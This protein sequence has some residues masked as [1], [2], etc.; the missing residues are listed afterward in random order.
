MLMILF[1]SER[2]R[3]V[4]L[5]LIM[6]RNETSD[7]RSHVSVLVGLTLLLTCVA[8]AKPT[9]IIS[10]FMAANDAVSKDAEGKFTDWI[11]LHNYGAKA[12]DIGGLYLT[13]SKKDL[14]KF[15]LP[16]LN[17]PP[18]GY[19]L[20]WAKGED[21]EGQA[22]GNHT[23][24]RLQVKGDYLALVD[25]DG[26]S[27]IQDFGKKYPNQKTNVSF[28][29]TRDWFPGRLPI[30]Y[31]AFLLEPTPGAANSRALLG[32]VK[33]VS[34]NQ[35]RD[36]FEEPFDLKLKS[37]T[38]RAV[39][40][41]SID[42]SLPKEDS[43][44]VY[45]G[46]IRISKT[47]VLRTAAFKPG[48]L[49]SK[50]K[51]HSFIFAEDVGLQSSDGLP[52]EGFPYLWG[53][54][55][56][57]YGMDP[58]VINDPR[59]SDQFVNGLMSIPSIS[60]V[61]DVGHLFDAETGI[62]SNPGQQGREWERPCSIE[63]I[64]SKRDEEFQVDGGIRIRGG[65]SRDRSNPKHAFRF[66]F[67]DVYGP[68]KLEYP[69][70]GKSGAREFDNF[71]LRTFQNYSWS[72]EGDPKGIFIRDQFNRDLQLEMGQPAARGEFYHLFLNGQ[73]WGIYNTCERAE[74][75]YGA[76]Y[77]GGDKSEYDA[78]KVD[79]GRTV[80]RSTYTLIPT[81]GDMEA[82][83]KIYEIV[84]KGLQNNENYYALLG[85]NPDGVPNPEMETF[86]DVDNLI[87][88]MMIIFYG[89]N[90][91]A[92]ISLFGG[93]QTPNNWHGVRRRGSDEGFKFFI[94]D[95]EHTF[96]DVNQ[97]RTGPFNTGSSFE[98]TSP[99]WLWEKALENTE[100]RMAVADHIYK[101]FFNRGLLTP[102]TMRKAFLR[103]AEELE[104]AVVCESARW[105]DA[106]QRRH[107][108][109]VDQDGPLNQ[110]DWRNEINRI[111][112]NYIPQ[113]SDIVLGQL[114]S[115][116]VWPDLIPPR[117]NQE[118]GA[119]DNG[120]E[121]ELE[122]SN[123]GSEIYLTFDGTD[124]RLIGGKVSQ[125]A[126]RFKSPIPLTQATEVMARTNLDGEWSALA[127]ANFEVK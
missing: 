124:P 71:D 14:K 100:F 11:E 57:D 117:F 75:S 43:G 25:R 18:D 40:R 21:R 63:M 108:R 67:R 33:S 36:F 44:K 83:R 61:T 102:D 29:I 53:R 64:D 94:W 125:R 122:H 113:R 45:A 22:S 126:L 19:V 5:R 59:F 127:K 41:Y 99:Q 104:T 111:V 91:D 123:D 49:P 69:L 96:L 112:D 30:Q 77:L 20:F 89:G 110:L 90:L 6:I 1:S 28:G 106:S 32:T 92:P 119:V 9:L 50:V 42:G 115:Q 7:R 13:D 38:K 17:L 31:S 12:I 85:R 98:R 39:I 79:S 93:N 118:G 26:K 88:Y 70:F 97:D 51:T 78:V 56:V 37:K 10:E 87:A 121:L 58:E 48:Y 62:Y 95:A 35:K 27:V 15:A 8:E 66:F 72:F 81:D 68:S 120:F 74:A 76:T 107:S 60:V 2:D 109:R 103:R 23:N 80:R 114:Y 4:E 3:I 65:F 105:G 116:G 24:F 86:V 47:T 52:A 16:V 101:L 34:F 55:R 73:Y 46:S 84:Q 82:W 54:N